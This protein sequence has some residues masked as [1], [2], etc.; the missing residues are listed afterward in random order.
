MIDLRPVKSS[1]KEGENE[2]HPVTYNEQTSGN[3]M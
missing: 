2:R 1:T 3:L